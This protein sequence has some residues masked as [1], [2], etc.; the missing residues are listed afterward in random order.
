MRAAKGPPPVRAFTGDPAF[1]ARAQ[2]LVDAYYY[3]VHSGVLVE[4]L[5]TAL[6]Q[7]FQDGRQTAPASPEPE[8]P[9]AGCPGCG[10]VLAEFLGQLEEH[11]PGCPR[12]PL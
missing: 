12:F 3:Q 5:A 2:E 6:E 9:R 4:V 7:A 11:T 1:R 8:K 10:C